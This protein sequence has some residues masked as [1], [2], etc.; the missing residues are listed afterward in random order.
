[1]KPRSS[2][3]SKLAFALLWIFVFSIPVEKT[4]EIP[5]LGTIGRLAGLLALAGG[6]LAIALEG[7]FRIPTA[8]HLLMAAFVLWA[9]LSYRWSVAPEFTEERFF[10]NLQLLTVPLLIWMLCSFEQRCLALLDAYVFGALLTSAQ[11]VERFLSGTQTYYDRFAA[12]G[13]DPNDLALT[14]AI[15]LPIAYYLSLRRGLK[16][17]WAY[18]L[19]MAS[20][21][22]AI[23]LT[24]SRG[25]TL[26]MVAGL[27]LII[28]TLPSIPARRRMFLL[29]GG[30]AALAIA[31]ILVP[32]ASWQRLLTLAS[33]MSEGTLND[34]SV[35]WR[36]GWRVFQR[37]PFLGIGAGAYPVALIPAFGE[38]W[39]FTP[40]AHNSFL[41]VLVETGVVGFVLFAAMLLVM[42]AMA[43]RLPWLER[44]FWL[45]VLAVW[46]LGVSA[47]TWE[48]RKPTWF[49]FGI[50]VAH[51]ALCLDNRARR[52][53]P[54]PSPAGVLA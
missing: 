28:W 33:E 35:L 38:P 36:E 54:A 11:T 15:S 48:Y 27:S 20:A 13:F 9:A 51:T 6:A 50:L 30:I 7:R 25:G 44:C 31:L 1:M 32:A 4:I 18:L 23:L 17:Q 14:L 3:F 29:A 53:S 19:H 41:S 12:G 40:V 47:L 10:T 26:A 43:L 2:F 22:F 49:L 42:A 8:T 34:R 16:W 5:G 46:C 24:A 39:H 21:C 45:T 37:S 52:W